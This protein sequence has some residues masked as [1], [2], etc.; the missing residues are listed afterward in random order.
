MKKWEKQ[1]Y[2][3]ALGELAGVKAEHIDERAILERTL[4]KLRLSETSQQEAEAPAAEETAYLRPAG[5]GSAWG[6]GLAITAAFLV[7]LLFAVNAFAP[8]VTESLP[9]LGGFFRA[10]NGG[11]RNPSPLPPESNP[12]PSVTV[13]PKPESQ[14]PAENLSV[15]AAV[16]YLKVHDGKVTLDLQLHIF[17]TSGEPLSLE[18]EPKFRLPYQYRAK[19]KDGTLGSW[20][21]LRANDEIFPTDRAA[22]PGGDYDSVYDFKD[23][24]LSFYPREGYSRENET[25]L[26]LPVVVELETAGSPPCKR[27]LSTELE[28]RVSEGEEVTQNGITMTPPAIVSSPETDQRLMLFWSC[29]EEIQAEV[30]E[31][32]TGNKLYSMRGWSLE[33][34]TDN[35]VISMYP[36]GGGG[37]PLAEFTTDLE[38]LAVTPSEHYKDPASPFFYDGDLLDQDIWAFPYY[39]AEDWELENL[40]G[41]LKVEYFSICPCFKTGC[42]VLI[43][44]AADREFDSEKLS[45]SAEPVEELGKIGFGTGGELTRSDFLPLPEFSLDPYL[46]TPEELAAREELGDKSF[47]YGWE[48]RELGRQDLKLAVAAN[49]TPGLYKANG[50][51]DGEVWRITVR[52]YT[53]NPYTVLCEEDV[54]LRLPE[55]VPL[56]ESA[57]LRRICAPWYPYVPVPDDYNPED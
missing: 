53:T 24:T 55:N 19:A 36:A 57:H 6:F 46:Y 35:V 48:K 41:G 32:E 44:F 43:T 52:D 15:S 42:S 54:T 9:A 45:V 37:K 7:I 16:T 49:Q 22:A 1:L 18:G 27:T 31:L 14:N 40:Q 26:L 34:D 10:I 30:R 8:Q 47:Y 51:S 21:A 38:T 12:T 4:Q 5:A 29:E 25:W 20:N 3:S 33:D 23:L 39:R 13:S 28:V 56:P 2:A 17:S 50:P 11:N